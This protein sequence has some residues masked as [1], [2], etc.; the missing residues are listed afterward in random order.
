M[1]ILRK[2]LLISLFFLFS[3][4]FSISLIHPAIAVET[5]TV[6]LSQTHTLQPVEGGWNYEGKSCVVDL[7]N[8]FTGSA[9]NLSVV[10]NPGTNAL[11]GI[12]STNSTEI[13]DRFEFSDTTLH[14]V[15]QTLQTITEKQYFIYTESSAPTIGVTLSANNQT[16]SGGTIEYMFSHQVLPNVFGAGNVYV[17]LYFGSNTQHQFRI[18]NVSRVGDVLTMK[19]QYYNG[20]AFADLFNVQ[21]VHHADADANYFYL[22]YM[23]RFEYVYNS[24]L[25]VNFFAV[26]YDDGVGTADYLYDATLAPYQQ[27]AG[28]QM[29]HASVIIKNVGVANTPLVITAL[30]STVDE[31]YFRHRI[32]NYTS[33]WVNAYNVESLFTF[34]ITAN[35][36]RTYEKITKLE[37]KMD[38]SAGIFQSQICKV[39]GDLASEQLYL[40]NTYQEISSDVYSDLLTVLSVNQLYR[41][42]VLNEFD[43]TL[44]LRITRDFT[45]SDLSF[46]LNVVEVIVPILLLVIPSAIGYVKFKRTG[47]LLMFFIMTLILTATAMIPLIIGMLMIVTLVIIYVKLMKN[48]GDT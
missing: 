40:T 47:F 46:F 31:H 48:S 42:Y 10:G 29:N 24:Y 17:Y 11:W 1:T 34:Y 13:R 27:L 36:S 3:F 44:T 6:E 21:Y 41:C 25:Y 9:P 26:S 5:E 12:Y 43:V 38:L 16:H 8:Y 4:L 18:V 35:Y 28:S 14:A 32:L 15:T 30:D 39:S 2:S 45:P 22:S 20:A 19:W 37:L 23:L 7:Q 33:K